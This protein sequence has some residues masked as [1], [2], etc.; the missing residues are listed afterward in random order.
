MLPLLR[1]FASQ[2]GPPYL[3]ACDLSLITAISRSRDLQQ[4]QGAFVFSS[5]TP[6]A[7][8]SSGV[9]LLEAQL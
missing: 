5:D 3:A 1:C 7:C 2:H 8:D 9:A 4:C 6:D